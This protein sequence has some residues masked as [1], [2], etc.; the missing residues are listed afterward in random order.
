M[1]I[2][3]VIVAVAMGVD[4]F[5]GGLSLGVGG[6]DRRRWARTA[7]IFAAI[8]FV[9]T[10]LGVLFGRLLGDELGS[11]AS[12]IAG[13]VL[14]IVGFRALADAYF[15]EKDDEAAEEIFGAMTVIMT[16]VMVCIDKLAIGFTMAFLDVS[17]PG[18]IAWIVVISFVATFLGL[19]MGKRLGLHGEHI[20][21][22]VAG[23]LFVLLG[24]AII[25]Q[26]ASG[27]SYI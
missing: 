25:F 23:A 16:G 14:L 18:L 13:A 12:Y 11:H 8:A 17:I 5:A 3:M 7:A 9:M 27:D 1:T 26:T 6:L 19:A 4:V 24:L 20:A 22:Y 2:G 10:A 15:G 21:E